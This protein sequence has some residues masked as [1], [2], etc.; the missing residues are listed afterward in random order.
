MNAKAKS[1]SIITTQIP[2][3]TNT[4][5]FTVKGAGGANEHGQATDATLT[6]DL[7]KVAESVKARATIHGFIQRVSDKAA[8]SRNTENG[9]PAT[10]Q[11]KFEAMKGLVDHFMSGSEEWA[12]SRAGG[13]GRKPG[14]LD[15]IVLQAVAEVTGKDVAAV[16]GMVEAGAKAK[17]ITQVQFLAALGSSGKVAP[18][19]ERMRAEAVADLDG[20]ELLEGL[21]E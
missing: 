19:V 9:Q 17:A 2:E 18:V 11:E 6:L 13:S 12:P 1:N 16:R 8:I 14:G 20:D 10:P 3:G 15:I 5:V 7:L 4:I 21:G